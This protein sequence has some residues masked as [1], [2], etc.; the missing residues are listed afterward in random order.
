M[1]KH[2]LSVCICWFTT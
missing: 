2:T 1:I